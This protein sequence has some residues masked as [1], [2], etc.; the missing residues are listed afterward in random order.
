MTTEARAW[1]QLGLALVGAATVLGGIAGWAFG[2]VRIVAG[3]IDDQD[4][5]QG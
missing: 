1:T 3:A 5:E 2:M 4:M